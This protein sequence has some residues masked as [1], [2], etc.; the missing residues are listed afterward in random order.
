MMGLLGF[1]PARVP[2]SNLVFKRSSDAK[3]IQPELPKLIEDCWPVHE[4]LISDLGTKVVL[5]FE[6]G[7]GAK[8]RKL[9]QA[10]ELVDEVRERNNRRYRSYTH[11]N[12][13]GVAV[14]TVIHGSRFPWYV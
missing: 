6:R 4:K 5:C 8:V 10:S 13:E 14:V 2:M 11:V 3:S 9:L 1:N 12:S 7:T